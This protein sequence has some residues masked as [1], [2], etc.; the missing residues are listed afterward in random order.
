MNANKIR[1]NAA[2]PQKGIYGLLLWMRRDA[3]AAYLQAIATVPGVATF[4][5]SLRG[6]ALGDDDLDISDLTDLSDVSSSIDTTAF[7]PSSIDTSFSDST[8]LDS[9]VTAAVN[10]QPTFDQSTILDQ[11][12]APSFPPISAPADIVPSPPSSAA[13]AVNL[14]Q[15]VQA[16]ASTPST[17][18]VAATQISLAAAGQAPLLT[19]TVYP[20][21]GAPAYL[22]PIAAQPGSLSAVLSS[23]VMGLPVW[24][25]GAAALGIVA[26]LSAKD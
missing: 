21:S 23:S 11:A 10:T 14:G 4:E 22:A 2:I 7:D 17:P 20:S 6:S 13:G 1:A 16:L 12:T 3:P 18:K 19:G 15:V 5:K 24:I 9:D 26:L 8:V 25:F